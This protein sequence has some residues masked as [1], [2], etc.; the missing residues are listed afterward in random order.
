MHPTVP[1]LGGLVAAILFAWFNFATAA[2]SIGLTASADERSAAAPTV[3]QSLL[4][5]LPA[6]V[7]PAS[8]PPV[9]W[10]ALNQLVGER[11]AMSLTMDMPQPAS[12]A[13]T[14]APLQETSPHAGHA[15]KAEPAVAE[16]RRAKPLP[17]HVSRS[18]AMPA[19]PVA[20]AMKTP[21]P[22]P[23]GHQHDHQQMEH[24]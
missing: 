10:K 9:T 19:A 15:K 8:P 14:G 17:V 6:A 5:S 21:V 22:Q 13:D 12:P 4:P 20:P 3:Y 1:T 11:D 2:D 18:H 24:Q 7:Q 23:E 16:S